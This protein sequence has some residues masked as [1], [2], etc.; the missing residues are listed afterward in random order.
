MFTGSLFLLYFIYL[1]HEF[2]FSGQTFKIPTNPLTREPSPYWALIGLCFWGIPSLLYTLWGSVW[3]PFGTKPITELKPR[4][5][6]I[7]RLRIR[8]SWIGFVGM[9]LPIVIGFIR[10][11]IIK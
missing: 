11:I 9:L 2:L 5:I 4:D 10:R 8:A 3:G 6:M 7:L 1:I